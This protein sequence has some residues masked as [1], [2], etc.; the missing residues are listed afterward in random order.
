MS[1]FDDAFSFAVDDLLSTFG[2]M[3]VYTDHQNTSREIIAAKNESR[4]V[5]GGDYQSSY[6]ATTF[7]FRSG[8]VP[9]I[10]RGDTILHNGKT[11]IVENPLSEDSHFVEVIVK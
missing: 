5:I 10:N 4:E 2:D 6:I 11:W 3:I 8:L 7:S 1:D 9:E